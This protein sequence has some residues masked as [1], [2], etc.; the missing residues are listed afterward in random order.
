MT[1]TLYIVATPIGNLEDITL[2]ALRILKEVDFIAAEDTRHSKKLLAHYDIRT[3]LV[4]Y[5]EHNERAAAPALVERMLG[6]ESVALI[7]DAGTPG[8][9]DPGYRLTQAAVA[10]G[11]QVTPVPGPSALIAA[12]SVAALPTDRFVFE[13]FLPEKREQRRE[14]LRML[15]DEPRTLVFYE[16]PHR[17]RDSLQD[18]E[19]ILGERTIVLAREMS[20]LHEEVLRGSL[21][22]ISDRIAA[23]EIRGEVALVVQGSPGKPPVSEELLK[24]DVLQLQARGM[25]VKDIADLLGEKYGLPKKHIYRVALEVQKGSRK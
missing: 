24:T 13:G 12:L 21:R 20:K 16:A 7:S 4:S 19:S 10:A 23:G 2:R 18:I 5:H 11:V 8:I 9:S 1:G 22:A 6:G 3:P 25:R 17:L 14:R 15:Q